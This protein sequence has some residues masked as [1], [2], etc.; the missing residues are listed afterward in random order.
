MVYAFRDAFGIKDVVEDSKA[1]LRGRGMDYRAFEPAGGLM[2][3]GVGLENRIRAGLRYSKG[4]RK[5][6]WLPKTTTTTAGA[7]ERVVNKAINR[8]VGSEAESV[9][10]PLLA[11]QARDV[12]HLASDLIDPP[13][14][15]IIWPSQSRND[16][17]GEEGDDDEEGGEGFDLPFGDI[18]EED[19]ELFENS[20][21]YLFGDYNYPIIDVSSEGARR[22]MWAEEE[23]VLRD[24]RSAWFSPIRGS[25][26]VEALKQREGYFAWK[27]YGAVNHSASRNGK[28]VGRFREDEVDERIIDHEQERLTASGE[29]SS[30]SERKDVAMRWTRHAAGT[31]TASP[32]HPAT[33]TVPPPPLPHMNTRASHLPSPSSPISRQHSSRPVASSSSTPKQTTTGVSLPPDAVDLVVEDADVAEQMMERRR[34]VVEPALRAVAFR[35]VYRSG[36]GV[37]GEG[38]GEVVEVED[39]VEVDSERRVVAS[40]V[41]ESSDPARQVYT[42]D[43]DHNP[44]A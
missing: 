26:G 14:E 4:G 29:G 8:V 2:H 32:F 16:G 35:K 25:R 10:A 40:D 1:T 23:R 38:E 28:E 5:K 36:M 9:H 31:R 39:G 18:N 42:F 22:V 20:K 17:D 37:E 15:D 24:E 33:H 13:P 27:G 19:E 43:D 7:E 41:E 30:S 3:Q 11:N 6:Y 34:G 12:V 44:W 21:Q